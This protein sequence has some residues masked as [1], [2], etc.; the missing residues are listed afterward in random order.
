MSVNEFLY[1][2]EKKEMDVEKDEYIGRQRDYASP[3]RGKLDPLRREPETA[4]ALGLGRMTT[5]NAESS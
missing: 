1:M 5:A 2:R 3:R 4:T